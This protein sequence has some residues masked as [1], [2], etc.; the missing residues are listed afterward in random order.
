M[1]YKGKFGAAMISFHGDT[2]AAKLKEALT[3]KYGPSQKPDPSAEKLFGI[4][5]S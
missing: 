2:N 3:Q 4:F 5:P 1:F